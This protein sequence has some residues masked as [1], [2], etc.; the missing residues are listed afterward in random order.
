MQKQVGFIVIGD[1]ILSGRTQ[2]V[3]VQVLANRLNEI[4]AVLAEVRVV[5]DDHVKIVE[6]IRALHEAYDY[7]MS[8]GGIGPTHDD[9][10][11]DCVAE[12]FGVG[13]DV[14][15]DAKAILMTNYERAETDLTQ[16]NFRE[17]DITEARLRMA[18]I[19]DGASLINNPISKAPGFRIENMFVMAGVPKIFEVM[20]DH[21]LQQIEQGT[22]TISK[23]VTIYKGES[24]VAKPLAAIA[25]QFSELSIGSYPQGENGNYYVE[26]VVKGVGADTIEN[27][28][29]EIVKR[30]S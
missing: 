9:I 5:P 14:R 18:R 28:L 19:P 1:E 4:G 12:A 16:T 30:C 8:S 20:L 7:V 10:T 26:I 17:K 11:A 24:H 15:E 2:D 21:S 29:A 3:N 27:A 22:V 25:K 23:S 6:T 13:I